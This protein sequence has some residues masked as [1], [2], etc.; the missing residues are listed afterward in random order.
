[1]DDIK[2]T[3]KRT[4]RRRTPL[5]GVDFFARQLASAAPRDAHYA[6]RIS[7]TTLNEYVAGKRRLT[8][9]IANRLQDWSEGL[10][11]ASYISACKTL[12]VRKEL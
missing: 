11:H 10:S 12:G 7:M 5:T 2:P 6:T 8:V 1:M 4:R 3:K 9:D